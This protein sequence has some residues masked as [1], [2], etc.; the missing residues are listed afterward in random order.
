MH[1]VK[2]CWK[3]EEGRGREI[4]TVCRGQ[5]GQDSGKDQG[6]R[7]GVRQEGGQGMVLRVQP[8]EWVD[9]GARPHTEALEEERWAHVEMEKSV[10]DR[11]R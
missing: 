1:H 8:S 9:G 2:C 6:L 3:V 5:K 10:W 7:E 11:L 4:W